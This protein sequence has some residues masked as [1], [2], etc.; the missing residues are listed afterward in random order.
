VKGCLVNNRLVFLCVSGSLFAQFAAPSFASPGN[1]ASDD[2]QVMK[3]ISVAATRGPQELAEIPST[4]TVKDVAE[5]EAELANDIGDLIRYEPGVSVSNAVTRF[6][7]AGFNI[8]GIDGNRVAMRIDNIRMNDAFSIGSFSDARRNLVELDMLKTVEIVR[9]PA[10]ALY[11]SDAIGGV[12]SF[13]TKD[14]ADFL[15]DGDPMYFGFT[16]GYQSD[17]EGWKLG[18]TTAFGGD[19]LAA[20]VSYTHRGRQETENRGTVATDD[21][22]RT[23]PNP[24]DHA[25][26]SLLAKSTW[27]PSERH[28]LRLTVALDRDR[29]ETEVLSA[30]GRGTGAFSSIFT[31]GLD[32]DDEQERARIA[33]DHTIKAPTPLYDEL[34]WQIYWQS[35]DVEQESREYRYT[36]AGSGMPGPLLQRDRLFD[37]EQRVL[38]GETVLRKAFPLGPVENL[39][40]YGIDLVMTKTEQLRDGL[41]R[42]LTTGATTSNISPDNFPVRDFPN[43]DTRQYAFFVQDELSISDGQFLLIPGARLDYYKLQPKSDG[44]FAADNPGVP[45]A[46]LRETHVS[47]KLGTVWRMDTSHSIYANYARGFRAPPYNDVNIGFTN[48]VFG[49]TAIPNGDLEPETS[50]GYEGGLRGNYDRG[51]FSLAGYYNDYRDFINSM[52]LVG[53]QGSTIDIPGVPAGLQVFQSR[54]LSEA[55]IYGAELR[56]GFE[57]LERVKLKSSVAYAR[58]DGRSAPGAPRETLSSV[59]PFKGVLGIAYDRH[60]SWGVELVATVVDRNERVNPVAQFVPGGYATFDL[61]AN[62]ALGKHFKV[63]AGVFNLTDK[64]Y[65]AWSDVRGFAPTSIVLDRYTQPGINASVNVSAQF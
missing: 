56:A 5:I 52:N 41:Q 18:G 62:V 58:G 39:L 51:Y 38:G 14:P 23:V 7:Q 8:R 60:E 15:V 10:S 24:Q 1:E 28:M 49:Y 36:I 3:K 54:N 27:T 16:S 40:T 48:L 50:N 32:G 26:D 59:D 20:L 35:T 46:S 64:K 43:T 30:Q 33:F 42:N 2:A 45:I 55:R 22:T 4:V 31:V 19:V 9:G 29:K 57:I 21:N 47:P 44:I 25:S 53:V 61:L 65:W 34:E 17:N 6:G 11:G 37:F 63:H 13:V 12:V